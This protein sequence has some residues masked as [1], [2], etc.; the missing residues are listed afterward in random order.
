MIVDEF[1]PGWLFR[2]GWEPAMRGDVVFPKLADLLDLPAAHGFEQLLVAGVRRE[3]MGESPAADRGAVGFEAVA[4]LHLRS[5][6][7]VG[8]G[9]A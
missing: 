5:G 8:S 6:K 3:L 9:R 4:A 7:A 1:E 2:Q